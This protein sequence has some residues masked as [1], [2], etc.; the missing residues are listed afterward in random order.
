MA[1]ENVKETEKS[2]KEN[3][4]KIAKEVQ[5]TNKNTKE[6]EKTVKE[7]LKE[8]KKQE[9][10]RK[11]EKTEADADDK[12]DNDLDWLKKLGEGTG[13]TGVA[14]GM[15]DSILG[16]LGS[17]A[18][19]FVLT[20]LMENFDRLQNIVRSVAEA[21]E[22]IQTARGVLTPAA[23]VARAVSAVPNGLGSMRGYLS[24]MQGADYVPPTAATAAAGAADE[25][26][27]TAR[28]AKIAVQSGDVPGLSFNESTGRFVDSTS[29]RFVSQADAVVAAER[30]VPTL[31]RPAVDTPPVVP[32]ATAAVPDSVFSRAARRAGQIVDATPILGT[33]SRAGGFVLRN[34]P[35]ISTGID[36]ALGVHRYGDTLVEQTGNEVGGVALA[37]GAGI[38]EGFL[39]VG[40]AAINLTTSAAG[41]FRGAYDWMRGRE[42]GF[43]SGLREGWQNDVDISSIVPDTI[44]GRKERGGLSPDNYVN[45]LDEFGEFT[46]T[47]NVSAPIAPR[48]M[49]PDNYV[50]PVDEFAGLSTDPVIERLDTIAELLEQG[51]LGGVVAPVFNN[52]PST[53]VMPS[54]RLQIEVP[55]FFAP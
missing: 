44:L 2:N 45:P 3:L 11:R 14:S 24:G 47:S 16:T 41:G 15:S 21:F 26:A 8:D 6:T 51:A 53:T 10:T 28:A 31:A 54:S 18:G 50:N 42:G 19:L 29:G 46:P 34:A 30:A 49:S 38:G 40:D 52:A 12:K 27:D 13:A 25:A 17:A 48:V 22:E 7:L 43:I 9:E 39:D 23:A 55:D 37:A 4:K 35:V 5:E 1:E 32:S 20:A 33:A 36:A